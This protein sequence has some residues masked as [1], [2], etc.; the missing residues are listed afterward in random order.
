MIRLSSLTLVAAL[1]AAPAFAAP[2]TDPYY[3]AGEAALARNLA[4][5]PN[6]GRAKNVILFLG[7]G[8][9]IST[10]TAGR[11]FE[12]QSRGVD[13]E[14]SSLSFE[15]LPWT[16]LSKTYSHDTQVTDSAAGITAITT[17]VKTRNKVI[18]LTGAAQP[19]QC[20]TEAANRVETIA[21]IAKAHGLSA[22][23]VTTTRITH[24]TPAGVYAHTAYRDWEGDTDMPLE[25]TQAGCKDIARQLIEAPANLRLDV[26]M[27]GG[28]SR[29]LPDAAGGKRGD[30]RDLTAEWRKASGAA[31]VTTADQLAALDPARTGPVL[32]LFANE[33]LPYEVE[34]PILGEGVPT[35]AQMTT[36]AIDLLNKNPKGYFLLVEGGKI[37]MGSHLNNAKRTLTET[38][39]FSKAIQAA[40]DKVDLK[41]T[42]IIVT[43]DHSHGLVISGYAS[44][45]API[46]GLAGNE[47]E[48]IVAGDG[49]PY[50]VLSFATGPG[51]PEGQNLRADPA[52]ED[53]DDVDYHQQ[54]LANLPSAA[55][56]GEDVGVFAD[57]PGAWLVHG[58]VEESYIFQVMRHAFGFDADKR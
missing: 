39:E 8:M 11:I 41:D 26:A 24:A 43:A 55:H 38:A 40:L 34:R 51:G 47:G 32:G 50:S 15:K 37:D 9:G 12:G 42:L 31:Y 17:G 20:A 27:G 21:E 58:V 44:R 18:G 7:D 53:M 22:G 29:F 19:E 4:I 45:N 6:T 14:S 52:K 1:L 48:P 2:A 3:K 10:I 54:A 46:L 36:K 30:G 13:G 57:G 56:S 16:A 25:A 35:L 5:T 33:H 28:R 23:A 49:K